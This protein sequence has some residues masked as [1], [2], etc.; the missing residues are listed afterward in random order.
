MARGVNKVILVGNLGKDPEIQNFENS[1]KASFSLATTET[2]R[3][4]DGND[5]QHTEW[6]NIVTWGGLSD[7]VEQYLKK[8]NQLYVEGRI[9]TRSYEGKDGVKRNI[10][11]IIA[12]NI[13]ML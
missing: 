3:G 1:K 2:F 7:V 8:G 12:D 9:R 13:L 6:H 5:V 4:K 10:T 11:E